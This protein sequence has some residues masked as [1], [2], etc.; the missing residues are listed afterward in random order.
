MVGLFTLGS[1]GGNVAHALADGAGIGWQTTV[2]AIAAAVFPVTTFAMTHVVADLLVDPD[3]DVRSMRAPRARRTQPQTTPATPALV[4][5]SGTAPTTTPAPQVLP[6]SVRTGAVTGRSSGG[7]SVTERLEAVRA[8]D[9]ERP[10]LSERAAAAALCDAHG[11]P[12]WISRTTVARMRR[13][14]A[15]ENGAGAGARGLVAVG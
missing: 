2:G 15:E 8:L 12:G 5:P 14:I 10:G 6:A 7:A 1:M 9:V 3:A 11:D 13:R 4:S